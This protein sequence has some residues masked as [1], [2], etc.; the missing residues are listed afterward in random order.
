LNGASSAGYFTFDDA[1]IPVGGGIVTQADVLSSLEFSWMGTDYTA[2][3]ANTGFVFFSPIPGIFSI[4]F[5]SNCTAVHCTVGVSDTFF[6]TAFGSGSGLL[7]YNLGGVFGG[8]TLSRLDQCNAVNCG[9]AVPLPASGT[10]FG[11]ALFAVAAGSGTR[12]T[13]SSRS[14]K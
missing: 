13:Q 7:A 11:L 6:V 2:S 5:G 12:R 10:L 9:R 14:K 4:T 3:T 8:G 1:M